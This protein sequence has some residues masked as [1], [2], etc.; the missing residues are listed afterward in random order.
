M[1]SRPACTKDCGAQDVCASNGGK[2][3]ESKDRREW[4]TTKVERSE[5]HLEGYVY[6]LY[7]QCSVSW[8]PRKIEG[9]EF[10]KTE[11]RVFDKQK[12]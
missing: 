10:T 3:T 9:S 7:N 6:I 12:N 5:A 1:P 4:A 2:Q 11:K 8:I